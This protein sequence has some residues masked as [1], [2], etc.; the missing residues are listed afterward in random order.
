MARSAESNQPR[1]SLDWVALEHEPAKRHALAGTRLRGAWRGFGHRSVQYTGGA[2]RAGSA[3]CHRAEKLF[4]A[5]G[6]F[7]DGLTV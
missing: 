4:S 7:Q 5:Y 1:R 3:V 2:A 6:H